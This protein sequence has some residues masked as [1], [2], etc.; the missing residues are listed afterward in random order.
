[1]SSARDLRKYASSTQWR[2]IA[3]FFFLLIVV[4]DGLIW[5]FYGNHALRLALICTT[6]AL[7]PVGLIAGV[8]WI[9]EKYL[10]GVELDENIAEDREAKRS[11]LSNT[12][13]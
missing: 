9:M 11:D 7:I 4:G 1:M 6:V 13:S 12:D 3:G 2:L 8:L 5:F 10:R